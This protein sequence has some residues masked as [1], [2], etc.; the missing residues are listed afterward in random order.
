MLDTVENQ[1]HKMLYCIALGIMPCDFD[2]QILDDVFYFRFWYD[3]FVERKRENFFAKL[4][5]GDKKNG[6]SNENG[7]SVA[8][9][10][11]RNKDY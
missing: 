10:R 8:G 7:I 4:L 6:N 2:S 5:V 9:A 11:Q 1:Y 3:Y